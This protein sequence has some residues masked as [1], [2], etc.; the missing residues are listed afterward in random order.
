MTGWQLSGWHWAATALLVGGLLPALA[1]A[2]R[3]GAGQR[4]LGLAAAAP[5]TVMA[6]AALAVD[7]GQSSL[8]IVPLVLAVLS[9]TGTVM[10][11]RLLRRPTGG[12]GE[13][14]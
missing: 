6:L 11:A 1:V 5:V 12:S 4:L 10:M 14:R 13:G 2:C 7:S 8:L 3:G 9:F